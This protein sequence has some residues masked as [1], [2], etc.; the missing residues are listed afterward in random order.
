MIGLSEIVVIPLMLWCAL[1]AEKAGRSVLLGVFV[2]LVPFSL[3]DSLV[4]AAISSDGYWRSSVVSAVCGA[5]ASLLAGWYFLVSR[6]RQRH[7]DH[8]EAGAMASWF[9][10][11]MAF[12][13]L[14]A[15]RV[16]RAADMLE[17]TCFDREGALREV[18]SH[19]RNMGGVRFALLGH[20]YF[21]LRRYAE[22]AAVFSRAYDAY[23]AAPD[24]Y[25]DSRV[26]DLAFLQEFASS[27]ER[28]GEV[29]RAQAIRRE[30]TEY[31]FDDR[32]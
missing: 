12:L 17:P 14:A 1:R 31:L 13:F 9:R 5:G 29:E 15:R 10:V 2:A 18:R 24:S 11:V 30:A 4:A 32:K 7:S 23:Q 19:S 27:L 6:T 26:A 22:A 16:D 3:V 20:C 28:I 8:L 21:R 25:N